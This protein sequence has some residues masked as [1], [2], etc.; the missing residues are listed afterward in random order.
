MPSAIRMVPE[1][2]AHRHE[3]MP[4]THMPLHHA[5]LL[6]RCMHRQLMWRILSNSTGL[7]TLAHKA[8]AWT[9]VIH[10]SP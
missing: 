4:S 3:H 8:N 10:Q 2:Q 5:H 9:V 7:T 1:S 6:P